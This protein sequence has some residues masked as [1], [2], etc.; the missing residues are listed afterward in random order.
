MDHA[1]ANIID[2]NSEKNSYTITSKFTTTAKEAAL[3]RSE[4]LMHNKEQQLHE[5]FYN[6][7]GEVIVKQ[8]HVLLFGPTNAKTELLNFLKKDL[9]F[10]D[11]TIDVKSADK[12]TDNEQHAFVKEFFEHQAQ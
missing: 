10:K 5:A 2:I 12:M 7:I 9:H 1:S 11:I 6:D 4:I 8:D 3:S